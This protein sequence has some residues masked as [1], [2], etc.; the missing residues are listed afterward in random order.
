MW[1]A[2]LKYRFVFAGEPTGYRDKSAPEKIIFI[3]DG[4]LQAMLDCQHN[5]EAALTF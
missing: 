5:I 4:Q 3:C 1:P 2:G